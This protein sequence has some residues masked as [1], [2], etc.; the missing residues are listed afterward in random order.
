MT[1]QFCGRRVGTIRSWVD[2]EFCSSAHRKEAARLSA[3]ALKDADLN[4]VNELWFSEDQPRHSRGGAGLAIG[5]GLVAVG[6]ILAALAVVGGPNATGSGAQRATTGKKIG[7]DVATNNP[8]S[9]LLSGVL[10]QESE[11]TRFEDFSR[12]MRDWVGSTKLSGK[13]D[14]VTQNGAV[15]LGSIRLWTRSLPLSD[16]RFVFE[17]SVQRAGLGW[18]FRAS[19]VNNYYASRLRVSGDRLELVRSIF[20]SGKLVDELALPIPARLEVGKPFRV[21]MVVSGDKF[22]TVLN[23]QQVDLWRDDRYRQGGVGFFASQ[24]EAASLHWV[25]VTDTTN[26][27]ISGFNSPFKNPIQGTILLSPVNLY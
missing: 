15:K 6:V 25:T 27:A 19:N 1:C 16:Y 21:G 23:G 17:G 4:L 3:R 5:L 14:W 24:G 12:G 2:K 13:D 20:E 18:A 10:P 26:G 11:N 8:F 9:D 22:L 7:P